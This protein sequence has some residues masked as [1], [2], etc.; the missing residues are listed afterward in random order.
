VSTAKHLALELPQ[1]AFEPTKT[2]YLSGLSHEFG[3][4]DTESCR[5]GK[6][7]TADDA[8]HTIASPVRDVV[9]GG[10]YLHGLPVPLGGGG[11]LGAE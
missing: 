8:L 6:H 4:A 1:F 3:G 5:A 11:L 10:H 2:S 7:I 9:R